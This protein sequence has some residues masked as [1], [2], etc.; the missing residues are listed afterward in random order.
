MPAAID[1]VNTIG[2]SGN[3][4]TSLSTNVTCAAADNFLLALVGNDHATAGPPSTVTYNG[5]SM[6]L[7]ANLTKNNN[8]ISGNNSVWYL[9][10]PTTGSAL[11][12]VVTDAVSGFCISV[13]AIPMSGVNTGL[14]PVAGTP[15]SGTLPTAAACSVSGG[16]AKDLQFA[17]VIARSTSV[18]GPGA[19]QNNLYNHI[20]GAADAFS[21]DYITAGSA[22]NFSW[23]LA[24]L[25]DW[26]AIGV[27]VFGTA[28]GSTHIVKWVPFRWACAMR[29]LQQ[30]TLNVGNRQQNRLALLASAI[31]NANG[32]ATWAKWRVGENSRVSSN[33][34]LINVPL[35]PG[36]V[37]PVGTNDDSV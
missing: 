5:A 33:G 23:T 26:I 16:A 21:A 4:V 6:T 18:S 20:T 35:V 27:T 22:G 1:F 12:L 13:C 28:S 2:N 24:A 15:A 34:L 31:T 17:S 36:F 29:S 25:S 32:A 9:N 30:G 11:P 3:A 7:L 37:S 19:P 8:N 10:N 14:A